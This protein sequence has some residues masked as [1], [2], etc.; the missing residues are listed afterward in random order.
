MRFF[1]LLISKETQDGGGLEIG[2]RDE[3]RIE[4]AGT[5]RNVTALL[6]EG[7][8]TAL[9]RHLLSYGPSRS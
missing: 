4:V 6:S 9:R 2:I 5:G 7:C 3:K 8:G 1:H